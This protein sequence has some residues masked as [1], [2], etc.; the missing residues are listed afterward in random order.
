MKNNYFKY[1][2]KLKES[3]LRKLVKKEIKALNEGIVDNFLDAIG[4]ANDT[5]WWGGY[6]GKAVLPPDPT[7]LPPK[8][9]EMLMRAYQ[10]NVEKVQAKIMGGSDPCECCY[11]NNIMIKG[12]CCRFCNKNVYDIDSYEPQ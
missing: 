10:S 9:K 1:K 11:G 7:T 8:E 5:G 2:D 4:W 3:Q 6:G 12:I